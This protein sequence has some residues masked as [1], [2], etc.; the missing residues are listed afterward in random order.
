MKEHYE[1]FF[2]L[3]G[4]Y[5]KNRFFHKFLVISRLQF[6]SARDIALTSCFAALYVVFSVWNLFPVVGVQGRFINAAVITAPLMGMILGPFYGVLSITIGGVASAFLSPFGVFGPLSFLPHAAAA[7]ASGMLTAKKQA[8]CAISYFLL[9]VVFA[10]F[11]SSGPASL[12][13]F[14]LWLDF[15]GLIVLT[16]PLQTKATKYLNEKTCSFHLGLG[17][18]ATCLSATLFGHIVG[19][20]LF[21]IL[22]WPMSIEW[23]RAT[24]Q[25]LTFIY[26]IERIMIVVVATVVGTTLIKALKSTT[27]QA[28]AWR[29]D[30]NHS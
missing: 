17:V 19:C 9:F 13:P 12:W 21:E 30:E 29:R 15:I 16:S 18:F 7:F 26:P 6:P 3:W 2:G 24:W 11:P 4:Q 1:I 23:W 22:Y 5:L 20:I 8:V 27:L 10:R 14:M 25:T 28:H